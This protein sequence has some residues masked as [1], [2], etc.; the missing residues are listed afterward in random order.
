MVP[1]NPGSKSPNKSGSQKGPLFFLV[2][3]YCMIENIEES[4]RNIVIDICTVMHKYGYTEVSVGAIL[5][6]MGIDDDSASKHDDEVLVLDENFEQVM[7]NYR[8]ES[9]APETVPPGTTIQ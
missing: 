8:R 7:Q 6:L 2:I 3:N 5:R 1:G 4:V 9:A